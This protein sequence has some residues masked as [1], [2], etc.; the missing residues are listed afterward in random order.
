MVLYT[1]QIPKDVIFYIYNKLDEQSLGRIQ[2]TSTVFDQYSR[3]YYAL[4]H[5]K[6]ANNLANPECMPE[7]MKPLLIPQLDSLVISPFGRSFSVLTKIVI[8]DASYCLLMQCTDSKYMTHSGN[9]HWD[10]YEFDV[11]KKYSDLQ[12]YR[13]VSKTQL[14]VT[15]SKPDFRTING[16]RADMSS[17]RF[18]VIN[19]KSH[20]HIRKSELINNTYSVFPNSEDGFD[21]IEHTRHKNCSFNRFCFFCRRNLDDLHRYKWPGPILNHISIDNQGIFVEKRYM[22]ATNKI[23]KMYAIPSFW[24]YICT[25]A[26]KT[27]I[28]ETYD[29]HACS[30]IKNSK[31]E[32]KPLKYIKKVYCIDKPYDYLEQNNYFGT[33]YKWYL[34]DNAIKTPKEYAELAVAFYRGGNIC[35][36]K[37]FRYDLV[38]ALW[39]KYD[40]RYDIN[41]CGHRREVINYNNGEPVYSITNSIFSTACEELI[42]SDNFS[43]VSLLSEAPKGEKTIDEFLTHVDSL[44]PMNIKSNT[45][46]DVISKWSFLLKDYFLFIRSFPMS[47]LLSKSATWLYA[48]IKK[49]WYGWC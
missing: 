5:K 14:L 34:S 31:K 24:F 19:E 40:Y 41:L 22:H 32:H 16:Q 23:E 26:P 43:N 21:I 3:E 6:I 47:V 37:R 12:Y 15:M 38:N 27:L 13:N 35:L 28:S 20:K 9:T 46:H 45:K 48:S 36:G 42:P 1:M 39:R 8:D 10:D 25:Q 30:V 33:I 7:M 11:K 2:R 18:H 44:F 29:M 17:W 4:L 49:L